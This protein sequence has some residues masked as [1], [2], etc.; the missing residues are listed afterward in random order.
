MYYAQIRWDIPT[1]EILCCQLDTVWEDTAANLDA[2]AN[3]LADVTVEP[4]AIVVLPETFATGFSMAVDRIA[5]PIGGPAQTML[6]STA[7]RLGAFVLGGLA[8]RDEDG[9]VR[10]QAI[11]FG[12]DGCQVARYA[13]IH[14]FRFAD[15]HNHY[16]PGR[17]VVTFNLPAATAAAMVCYDLR[18]PELFR[19]AVAAGAELLI[20]IANWPAQRHDHWRTLLR[21]RA[22]ENQAVVVG[23]NRCGSDPNHTYAGGSIVVGPRGEVLLEAGDEPGLFRTHIDPTTIRS[24]RSQFPALTDIFTPPP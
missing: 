8:V 15:E 24:W 5:E 21:A 19:R 17:D 6:A 9:H 2:A 12:P 1:V 14:L 7:R 13:K 20:V 23:V 11:C 10:N 4:D 16:A 3:L 18:F 22:I